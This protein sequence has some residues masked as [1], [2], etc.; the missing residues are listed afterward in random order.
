LITTIRLTLV[1]DV[2]EPVQVGDVLGIAGTITIHSVTADLIDVSAA[3]EK[4]YLPGQISVD[5]YAN[6]ITIERP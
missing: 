1:A 6:H 3:G 4:A 5:A 2:P